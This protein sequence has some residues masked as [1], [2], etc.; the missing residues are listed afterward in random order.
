MGISFEQSATCEYLRIVTA[1]ASHARARRHACAV[2]A[3]T[4]GC[5]R[6]GGGGERN[7]VASCGGLRST[8]SSPPPQPLLSQVIVNPC[9]DAAYNARVALSHAELADETHLYSV[10]LTCDDAL[11]PLLDASSDSGK[12]GPAAAP[13]ASPPENTKAPSS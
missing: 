9:G 1:A 5:A 10:E 7:D 13:S 4:P 3:A 12:V 2:R 8:S 6:G 11:R